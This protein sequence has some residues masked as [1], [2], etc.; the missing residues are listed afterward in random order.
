MTMRKKLIVNVVI[1]VSVMLLMAAISIAGF[2]FIKSKL[3]Y[4][5]QTSTPFQV[6]TTDLQ[7]ALQASVSDL[8]Q[9]SISVNLEELKTQKVSFEKSVSD[10]K[11]AEDALARLSGK[12]RGL[13]LEVR[14]LSDEIFQTAE[15]RL[16]SE[17]ETR[18]AGAVISE[19]LKDMTVKLGK[20]DVKV[21]SI[22][23]H[24]S[25]VLKENFESSKMSVQK[26]RNMESI[27]A[28]LEQLT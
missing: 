17:L 9:A 6:R 18:K 10:V 25:K 2:A 28:S 23:A 22:Q 14:K 27:K 16:Y 19:K 15:K 21:A 20:L 7:K 12:Q 11:E 24:H 26:L 4:L 13:Y 3:S 8:L 1:I 5:L